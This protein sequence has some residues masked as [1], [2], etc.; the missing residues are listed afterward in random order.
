[1]GGSSP[2]PP[3]PPQAAPH[4][5]QLQ[6]RPC[7]CRCSPWTVH[8]LGHMHCCTTVSS[9]VACGDLHRI[10]PMHCRGTACSTVGLSWASGNFFMPGAH[11]AFLLLWPW[12]L[13]GCFSHIF[14]LLSPSC[15]SEAVFFLPFPKSPFPEAPSVAHGSALA[16]NWSPWSSWS[17]LWSGKGQCW[18]LLTE[19]IPAAPLLPPTKTMPH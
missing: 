3:A 13:Q 12:W 6:P 17:W 10:V 16:R 18:A 4:R 14:L 15:C 19:D 2:S 1:M 7:P 8:P 11:P 5:L 9:R